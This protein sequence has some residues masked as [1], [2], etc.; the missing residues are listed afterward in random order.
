MNSLLF[1]R[2]VST[3]F[4]GKLIKT[5]KFQTKRDAVWEYWSQVKTFRDVEKAFKD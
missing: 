5:E 2:T 1:G 4:M 3:Y